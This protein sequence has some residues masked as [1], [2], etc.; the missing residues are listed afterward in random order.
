MNY[1]GKIGED[2]WA[3]YL[4]D[5][6]YDIV[7]APARKFYDWDIKADKEDKTLTFEVKYDEKAYWWAKRRKTPTEPN[8]YIEFR[9]T[10]KAEDSG[11]LASKADYYI[12]IMKEDNDTAYV[13]NRK[14]LAEFCQC[15]DFR[16]VGNSAT[17]DDN[18]E[19]WIPKLSELIL[20]KNIFVMAISLSKK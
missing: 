12:Y 15:S 8:L 16:V 9:N 10:T 7:T 3:N 11:I 5:K 20:N 13:F 4:L 14:E 2:L 1:S 17:G 6:G 19:G 18:A